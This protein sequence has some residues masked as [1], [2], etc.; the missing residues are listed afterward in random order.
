LSLDIIIPTFNEANNLKKLLPYLQQYINNSKDQII[1]VDSPDS[2]DESQ[3]ICLDNDVLY[4]NSTKSQRANQLNR[5]AKQSNAETILFL[6]ADVFPPEN[7]VSHIYLALKKNDCGLFAYR[8]DKNT[9]FL[10]RVNAYF[11]RFSSVFTGGGDQCFFIKRKVFDQLKGYDER[12][13]VMEDF[14]LFRRIKQNDISY[15]V[16]RQ[17]AIVSARKYDSNNYSRVNWI[18]LKMIYAF[19]KGKS[20]EQLIQQ[21]KRAKI[22]KA[23]A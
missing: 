18:N 1:V 6:H 22:K 8:F 17:K 16:L 11:T 7:F 13:D 3:A 2:M 12:Y 20:P 21:Y 19:K 23:Q 15:K 9:P 5:G 4:L 14:E 10:L